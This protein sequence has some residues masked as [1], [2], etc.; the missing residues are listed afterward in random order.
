MVTSR[1]IIILLMVCLLGSAL[2]FFLHSTREEQ[3][4]AR[5]DQLCKEIQ[6]QE[7]EPALD[8]MTKAARIGKLFQDPCQIYFTTPLLDG[9]LTRREIIQHISVARNRFSR[10]NLSFYDI[11]FNFPDDRLASLSMT[12]RVQGYFQGDDEPFSD[13]RELLMDMEQTDGTWRISRVEEIQV[14][15]P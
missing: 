14:L 5:L 10:L 6:K 2:F 4:R 12:M 7:N 15:E 8:S 1:N 13:V 11:T 9:R 3:I